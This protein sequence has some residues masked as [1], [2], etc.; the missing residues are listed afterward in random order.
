MKTIGLLLP[1]LGAGGAERVMLNIA[2]GFVEQGYEVDLI[3]LAKQGEYLQQIPPHVRVVSFF[4]NSN[5]LAMKSLLVGGF[6]YLRYL[7]NNNPV[8]VISTLSRTNV[9][10]LFFGLLGRKKSKLIVREA[11]TL[12][13]TDSLILKLLIKWFYPLAYKIVCVSQGVKE[14]LL[15]IGVPGNKLV[16][17]NNPIDY[18]KI[19][20]QANMKSRHP[21]IENKNEPIIVAAGRLTRAK[22]FDVLIQAFSIVRQKFPAKLIILGEGELRG[23]LLDIC[24]SL[25]IQEFVDLPGYVENPYSFLKAADV[26]VLSSRWE[27]FVNVLV[28]A[29]AVGTSVVATDCHSSPSEILKGGQ[30]GRLV[31]ENNSQLLAQAILDTLKTP[32]DTASLVS[33]AREFTV[34]SICEKYTALLPELTA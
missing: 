21:W 34:S 15:S 20:Q 9:F 4:N 10:S 17:I 7:R 16:V 6:K 29:M 2:N 11:T 1:T 24:S 23:Q 30:I 8:A 25:K 14:D 32:Q 33:R 19:V 5:F 22:G 12:N 13:N 31:A 3:L 18:D 26:F 28:E 27:G